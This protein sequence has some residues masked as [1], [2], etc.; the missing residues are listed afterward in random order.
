M[1]GPAIEVCRFQNEPPPAEIRSRMTHAGSAR[2]KEDDKRVCIAGRCIFWTKRS[3]I[4]TYLHEV[5]HRLCMQ[6]ESE[7][8]DAVLSHGPV[9][10]LVLMTLFKRVEKAGVVLFDSICLY[11]FQDRPEVLGSEPASRAE[12]LRFALL[13]FDDLSSSEL[14][15]E[16]LPGAALKLW[17]EHLV[18]EASLRLRLSGQANQIN[19]LQNQLEEAKTHHHSACNWLVYGWLTAT[20]FLLFSVYLILQWYF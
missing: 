7:G 14:A 3:L 9:F 19:Q 6:A 2:R 8:L 18:A 12:V 15:A 10:L 5:T 20:A 1:V 4:N 13:H 11:D 16:M 17:Q